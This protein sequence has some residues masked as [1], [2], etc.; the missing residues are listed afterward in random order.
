MGRLLFM[1]II[2]VGLYDYESLGIRTLHS[3]LRSHGYD[4][5]T[6][7]LKNLF[8]NNIN[9]PS[10][11]EL[12]LFYDSV[13][14]EQADIIG[15]CVYS[16]YFN[17]AKK[18]TQML[19][20]KTYAKVIW[21][22]I[23]PTILPE[24]CI[25]FTDYICLG[26]G[27]YPMLELVENIKHG[28]PTINIKNIW[29]NSGDGIHRNEVRNLIDI[30]DI[31]ALDISNDNMIYIDND[32]LEKRNLNSFRTYVTTSGRG[33]PFSCTYC[34]V[35]S[36]NKLYK[37][38]GKR[39]RRLTVENTINK[40]LD[41]RKTFK[42]MKYVDFQDDVFTLDPEW[43]KHFS[44]EYRKNI[45][46]PLSAVA[47]PEF[48]NDEVISLLKEAGLFYLKVGIQS[49]AEQVRKNVYK[50]HDSNRKIVEAAKVLDRHGVDVGYDIIVNNPYETHQ[51]KEETVNLFLSLP[52]PFRLNIYSLAYFPCTELTVRALMDGFITNDCVENNS[53][54]IAHHWRMRFS[55]QPNKKELFYN[56]N[57]Y[58]T[59]TFVPKFIVRILLKMKFMATSPILIRIFCALRLFILADGL[60]KSYAQHSW[61][62]LRNA[63][64]N[65]RIS[66]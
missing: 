42:N 33:C 65:F 46:L 20:K 8:F 11:K 66:S 41:T 51:D 22:G 23:H 54:K 17:L 37:G 36:L 7:F 28:R 53:E 21:G 32:R 49:G 58:L 3:F 12:E 39:T 35:S 44:Q 19:R 31:P 6:I 60:Y 40:I 64:A 24:E 56:T 45:G 29:V 18:I 2:L 34:C 5:K 62:P 16:T 63:Y 27:E 15:L 47:H 43:I 25:K 52:R 55:R 48:I 4:V 14:R 26:E 13:A 10:A 38:K 30:N 9:K 1:K 59:Q 61:G 50:R 57:I